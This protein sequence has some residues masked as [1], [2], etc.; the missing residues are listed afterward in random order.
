MIDYSAELRAIDRG[1]LDWIGLM[2]T[3]ILT[4]TPTPTLTL[5]LTLTLILTPR[6]IA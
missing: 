4:P 2:L 5:T 3:L 1:L 6:L